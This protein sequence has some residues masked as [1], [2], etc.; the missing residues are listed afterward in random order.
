MLR[1]AVLNI[2]SSF[3]AK[4]VTGTSGKM[5]RTEKNWHWKR[6]WFSVATDDCIFTLCQVTASFSPWPWMIFFCDAFAFFCASM[7]THRFRQELIFGC[8]LEKL[9]EPLVSCEQWHLSATP[10]AHRSMAHKIHCF[11]CW[12][13]LWSLMLS[14][15]KRKLFRTCSTQCILFC[16][17]VTCISTTL[18]S[19][20]KWKMKKKTFH[21]FCLLLFYNKHLIWNP[22]SMRSAVAGPQWDQHRQEL[23]MLFGH[24]ASQFEWWQQLLW[25]DFFL[26]LWCTWLK[27]PHSLNLPLT[28]SCRASALM[29]ALHSGVAP[30]EA[31]AAAGALMF[32]MD[33]PLVFHAVQCVMS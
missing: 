4:I 9:L 31:A 29:M 19:S 25:N 13:R 5:H 17:A 18:F 1:V 32:E 28:V 23:Q 6:S 20:E 30:V 10:D 26:S 12:R 11:Q 8:W 22:N 7:W 3:F 21:S 2:S 14:A 27:Q 33:F 15:V 24:F 16:F